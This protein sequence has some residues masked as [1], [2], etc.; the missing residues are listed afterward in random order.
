[1]FDVIT[2]FLED[3]SF[4]TILAVIFPPG[5]PRQQWDADGKYVEGSLIVYAMT[6]RKA[7]VEGRTE[8]DIEGRVSRG[9]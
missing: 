9:G 3:T 7:A 8:D 2:G 6:M 1:M 4:A 5:A